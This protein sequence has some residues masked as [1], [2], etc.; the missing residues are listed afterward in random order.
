M[1][2]LLDTSILIALE[3]DRVLDF[4]ALPDE[5]AISVITLAELE[6]GVYLASDD[7]ARA[8]RLATL[9][10]AQRRHEPLPI[11]PEVASVF[12]RLTA[13]IKRAGK[14]LAVTDRWIA[15]TAI[16]HG[17]PLFTQDRDFE[18]VPELDVRI[19]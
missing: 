13:T 11:S 2:G 6:S 16:S 3:S 4:D 18:N 9:N 17:V 15:A 1:R 14:S 19:V 5:S 12:A 10:A 7:S 8:D